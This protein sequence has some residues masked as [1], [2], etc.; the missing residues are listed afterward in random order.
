MSEIQEIEQELKEYLEKEPNLSRGDRHSYLMAIF[1]KHLEF[2]K[3]EHVV[4]YKD[5]FNIF[6]QAKTLYT[7]MKFPVRLTKKELDGGESLHIPMLESFIWYLNRN[8]LLKKAIKFDYT[9]RVE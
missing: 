4:N 6:A 1:Q 8:N 3:Y 7:K 2:Q 5:Y 9:D